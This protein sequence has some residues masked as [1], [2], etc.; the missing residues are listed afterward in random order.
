MESERSSEQ[1]L[2]IERVRMRLEEVFSR[3][4]LADDAFIQQHMNAQL[5]IPIRILEGHHSFYDLTRG[6]GDGDEERLFRLILEA[7]SRSEKLEVD[8]TRGMV[9]PLMK[10]RRK[11][12]ILHDLPEGVTEGELRKLLESS[13]SGPLLRFVKPEVNRTAYVEFAT[14][15]AAQDAALWLRS[16]KLGGA[17][18]QC[19]MK[20]QHFVRSYFPAAASTQ[21]LAYTGQQMGWPTPQP[22]MFQPAD[23]YDYSG[24]NMWADNAATASGWIPQGTATPSDAAVDSST[25]MPAEFDQGQGEHK[26]NKGKRKSNIERPRSSFTMRSMSRSEGDAGM[27]SDSVASSHAPPTCS[28]AETEDELPCG[29]VHDF[30]TYSRQQIIDVCNRMD[31]IEKPAG[32]LEFEAEENIVL[33]RKQACKKWAPD[34]TP[35]YNSTSVYLGGRRGRSR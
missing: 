27:Y 20:S 6:S 35:V 4:R 12:L 1:E 25:A 18:I 11:T 7:A 9:K 16:Q 17:D 33:F 15:R 10:H 24:M 34:V 3:K 31:L 23:P 8:K 22:Y 26:H 29:Y 28:D 14:D 21:G 5:Y 32:F 13:P 2:Q 30:R 19:S